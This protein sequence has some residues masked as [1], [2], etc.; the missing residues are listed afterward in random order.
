[1]HMTYSKFIELHL[2]CFIPG[3]V[4]DETLRVLQLVHN[5]LQS[6]ELPPRPHDVL[7]ELRDIS[8]MAMEHFDEYIAPSLRQHI[9]P[10]QHAAAHNSS[11]IILHS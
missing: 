6:G 2:V 8:S 10:L 9:V 11:M 4:I 5:A 7:Q 3:R 1:M